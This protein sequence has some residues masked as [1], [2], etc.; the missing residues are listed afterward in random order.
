M[1][2]VPTENDVWKRHSSEKTVIC[3]NCDEESFRYI[4]NGQDSEIDTIGAI[5]IC[6]TQKGTYLH[7]LR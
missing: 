5:K 2:E 7:S 4:P 1:T 3:P 6:S